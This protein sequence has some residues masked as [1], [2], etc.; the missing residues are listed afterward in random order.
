M[1][2]NKNQFQIFSN[3]AFISVSFVLP[4]LTF[5]A[6]ELLQHQRKLF[7]VIPDIEILA[8]LADT[9]VK[10]NCFK[11]STEISFFYFQIAYKTI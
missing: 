6:L 2:I 8:V 3:F 5:E 10:C 11:T 4:F 9:L 7:P 1:F